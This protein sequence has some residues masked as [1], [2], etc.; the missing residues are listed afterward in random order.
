[1]RLVLDT[2][3]LVSGLLFP[4]SVPGEIVRMAAAGGLT[5]CYDARVLD[6]YRVVLARPKFGFAAE[7]VE[8]L[9][10]QIQADGEAVAGRPLRERLPDPDDEPFLEVALAA[11][12]SCLVTRNLR[13]YPAHAREGMSVLSPAALLDLLRAQR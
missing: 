9:L 4:Y 3:V 12:A 7:H 11:G 13:H 10:S 5:L 1:M 8:E 6:E 2:N